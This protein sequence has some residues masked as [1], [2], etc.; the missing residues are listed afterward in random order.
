MLAQERK[1]RILN[2]VE[3][4]GSATIEK[5]RSKVSVSDMTI[6][7][8]LDKLEKD[9]FVKR[10]RGGVVSA[11]ERQ[12]KDKKHDFGP[13]KNALSCYA[14]REFISDGDVICLD[15]S[16]TVSSIV[17]H[18]N[19]EN[20]TV[21]TNSLEVTREVLNHTPFITLISSGGVLR[22]VSETF[23]GPAAESFFAEHG[24]DKLLLSSTGF[25]FEQGFTDPSPLD[26]QAKKA[27]IS[28]ADKVIALVDSSK[29]GLRSLMPFASLEKIDILVTDSN[30]SGGIV[31][32]LREKG[33]DVRIVP[34][35][36]E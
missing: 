30:V 16:S 26:V 2:I 35:E 8:D 19:N 12:F 23:V 21:L 11:S 36:K 14:A 10:V 28:S 6:W 18:L 27:M 1:K 15:G 24:I 13:V 3:L 32:E 29:F 33:V 31:A 34:V 9:G 17:S 20:L 25:T 7:R 5:I 22:D 4:N